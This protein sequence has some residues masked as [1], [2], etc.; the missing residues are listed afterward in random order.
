MVKTTGLIASTIIL[1]LYVAF[2]VKPLPQPLAYHDF[3]DKN[4]Y[5]G[6]HNGLNVI[7]NIFFLF[8]G[9]YGVYAV[10]RSA[11]FP[12][13]KWIYYC[14]FIAIIWTAF[15]SG[16]YHLSPDNDTLVWDRIPMTVVFM[17][18][19]AATIA[20]FIN[21][22]VGVCLWPFLVM[23]GI[24]SVLWWHYTEMQG[25]GDLRAYLLVQFYP[26]LFITIVLLLFRN[27]GLQTGIRP[28]CFVVGWYIIAKFFELFDKPIYNSLHIISG[29]SLKHIAAAV[30]T[31]Y[32][33]R[34]FQVKHG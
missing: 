10:A 2:F 12:T 14:L 11:A 18:L 20:E 28:L 21:P 15:G 22:R 34:M 29:H 7:S 17:S 32:L 1:V 9:T 27:K 4:T 16:Y 25:Y 8:T 3:A 24:G 13:L 23:S 26:V 30:S 31:W 5:W 6:I 33:V 19:L